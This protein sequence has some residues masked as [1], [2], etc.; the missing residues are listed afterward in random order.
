[1]LCPAVGMRHLQRILGWGWGCR[2]VQ[3][4]NKFNSV[5]ES[6]DWWYLMGVFEALR[7]VKV[8]N[9]N[10]KR[11]LVGNGL[12]SLALFLIQGDFPHP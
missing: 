7:A 5:C 3:I 11:L 9:K 2:S 4:F 6:T 1:M 8:A 12:E 10:N